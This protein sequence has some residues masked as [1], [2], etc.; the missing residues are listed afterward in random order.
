MVIFALI[1]DYCYSYLS[2][3]VIFCFTKSLYCTL[4]L[5]KNVYVMCDIFYIQ[6]MKNYNEKREIGGEGNF[7]LFAGIL[8]AVLYTVALHV[9]LLLLLSFEIFISFFFLPCAAP[10]FYWVLL[11]DNMG[12]YEDVVLLLKLFCDYMKVLNMLYII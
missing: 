3:H 2:T 8:S 4:V 11:E 12:R 7:I 9:T 1:C 6:C 10:V 5:L